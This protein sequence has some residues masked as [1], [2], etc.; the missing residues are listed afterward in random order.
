MI[1]SPL[2][3]LT[4]LPLIS[5]LTNSSAMLCRPGSELFLDHAAPAVIDHVFE[6]MP[7]VLEEALHRPCGRITQRA[8][9]MSLDVIGDI[10]QE[11]QLL[12]PRLPR[13]HAPEQPVHPAR[14]LATGR[15]LAAG[16]RHVEARDALEHADHAGGLIHDDY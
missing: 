4:G 13:E 8:D 9:G 1:I 12:A 10:D 16:F 5:T 6:L 7:V 11:R 3:A 2:R 15:A 14:A